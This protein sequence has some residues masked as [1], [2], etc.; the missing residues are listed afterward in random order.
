MEFNISI[1]YSISIFS[2]VFSSFLLFLQ[3]FKTL[4]IRSRVKIK[5]FKQYQSIRKYFVVRRN[6]RIIISYALIL[7]IMTLVVVILFSIEFNLF[8]DLLWF[9]VPLSL[10]S[11]S[12][13]L[14][15]FSRKYDFFDVRPFDQLYAEISK[16][17][18]NALE[19]RTQ[20]IETREN[21]Q[22]NINN[23]TKIIED[24][25]GLLN[26]N[27]HFKSVLIE[28]DD[29]HRGISQQVL[30]I[31]G[32][33]NEV[34]K[35]FI[36][37]LLD[38][39]NGIPMETSRIIDENLRKMIIEKSFD[40]KKIIERA[41]TNIYQSM[42]QALKDNGITE[43]KEV[44]LAEN[45]VKHGFRLDT[46]FLNLFLSTVKH[47]FV[48]QYVFIK[49]FYENGDFDENLFKNI[50][51]PNDY[52]FYIT[53]DYFANV[54]NDLRKKVP[55]W[56][57]DSRSFNVVKALCLSFDYSEIEY[58]S[59]YAI[60]MNVLDESFKLIEIFLFAVSESHQFFDSGNINENKF[61]ILRR[62]SNRLE[63]KSK[64]KLDLVTLNTLSAPRIINFIH[65][66][67]DYEFK[68]MIPIFM[69]FV[70]LNYYYSQ[71][72]KHTVAWFN[73]E[74]LKSFVIECL[75]LLDQ[76]KMTVIN[77]LILAEMSQNQGLDSRI[78]YDKNLTEFF[79]MVL[80]KLNLPS[81]EELLS[82]NKLINLIRK[83]PEMDSNKELLN[84]VILRI[85]EERL[86]IEK[87]AKV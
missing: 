43:N 11:V 3:W 14:H 38:Y 78:L 48:R 25:N 83:S 1:V 5:D 44:S 9:Y 79:K 42:M 16:L 7:F 49:L 52:Y 72:S 58:L 10:T 29:L 2:L 28:F 55:R 70:F 32:Y 63:R 24:I 27:N 84:S 75:I 51:I 45:L 34:K 35:R 57:I 4:R 8:K 77:F 66:L 50:I 12:G 86:T 39:L 26:Q 80:D 64:E 47:P 53:D 68:K 74:K 56:A 40:E 62:N 17:S 85:E 76:E 54:P 81:L 61:L 20:L 23:L 13:F 33:V 15:E 6:L 60:Q 36:Q 30:D 73:Y 31:E 22:D 46:A 82:K 69:N 67:Y 18:D 59:S 71:L 65:D 21:I 19:Y 37:S 87:M 41:R